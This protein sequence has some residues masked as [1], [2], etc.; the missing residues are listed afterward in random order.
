MTDR[1]RFESDR[2]TTIYT[3]DSNAVTEF[4]ADLTG[5]GT[6]VA[7]RTMKPRSSRIAN[8]G[9]GTQRHSFDDH[10]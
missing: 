5:C 9:I 10:T 8:P 1:I 3:L 6:Y 7:A 2:E 4:C